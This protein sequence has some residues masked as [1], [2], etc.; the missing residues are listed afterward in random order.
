MTELLAKPVPL[1]LLLPLRKGSPMSDWEHRVIE[2][3]P[4]SHPEPGRWL[5]ALEDTRRR[6]RAALEGLTQDEIDWM[7]PGLTNSIG[8][9]LY[10]T[11]LIETDYLCCD[12]LGMDDYFPELMALLPYADR[13]IDG[14]LI[15]VAGIPLSEHLARLDTIRT[16]FIA[17]VS[18]LNAEQFDEARSLPE[19]GYDISPAWTLH[20]LMQHEAEHR[21]EIMM[22]R[23]L[24]K[25]R[26]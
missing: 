22:I 23:S 1:D 10:H 16:Q 5:W 20:H 8:T 9:L 15:P 12:I 14:N 18:Q 7:P 13:D 21:G 3:L 17:S 4:A 19:Y 2:S 24:Y 6:T 11:A 26:S 25:A